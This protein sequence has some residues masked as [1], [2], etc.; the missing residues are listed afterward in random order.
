[1]TLTNKSRDASGLLS[2]DYFMKK[3]TTRRH[4]KRQDKKPTTKAAGQV[5]IIG[6]Q[7]KRRSIGFIDSDGLRPTPDRLRETVFNWLLADIHGARV[8]DCCAGSGVLGFEALSRGAA[9]CTFIEASREQ[10]QMLKLSAETLRLSPECHTVYQGL[11][12]AV[13][14]EADL[15]APFDVV[16]IDPPYA[17]DLW[18]PILSTL[19]DQQLIHTDTLIYL[20]ADKALE[21]QLQELAL[22]LQSALNLQ[23]TH[24]FER[25]KQTKVGQAIAGLYRLVPS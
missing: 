5:R 6:G 8:L 20:E 9:H 2:T 18:Q 12:E 4:P 19:I 16:F 11:A 17:K 23:H 21:D 25:L 15:Q 10:A 13:L 22:K 24:R 7:F 3:N 14:T 1:M